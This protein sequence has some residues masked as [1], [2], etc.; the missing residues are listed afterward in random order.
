MNLIVKMFAEQWIFMVLAVIEIAAIFFVKKKKPEIFKQFCKGA[1]V[2]TALAV[3]LMAV[4][5]HLPDLF[6]L[7][8]IVIICCEMFGYNITGKVVAVLFA[9]FILIQVLYMLNTNGVMNE[10]VM[11][12]I[13]FVMQAITAVAVGFVMDKHIRQLQAEKKANNSDSDNESSES[14]EESGDA[15]YDVTDD[16]DD[17]Y[18]NSSEKKYGSHSMDE[19]DEKVQSIMDKVNVDDTQNDNK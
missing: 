11:N 12:I 14:T 18:A 13:F 8:P 6:L 3:I 17:E 4:L 15:Q 9:D 19:L 7:V 5:F 10:T 1:L 16:N 2:I